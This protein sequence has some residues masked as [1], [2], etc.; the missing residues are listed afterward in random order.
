MEVQGGTSSKLSPALIKAKPTPRSGF[1]VD[2]GVLGHRQQHQGQVMVVGFTCTSPLTSGWFLLCQRWTWL[3]QRA[4]E[5]L[6]GF[7]R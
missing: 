2:H 5:K 1:S 3:E 6:S 4:A 7:G